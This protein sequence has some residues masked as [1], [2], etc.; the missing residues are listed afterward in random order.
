MDQEIR[1]CHVP[2][3]V[4]I[5]Y[6]TSGEGPLLVKAANWL[7]HLEFDWESPIWRHVFREL[8]R[9]HRLVRYDERGNGLSD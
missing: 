2:D 9:D 8:T 7:N 4:R 1:F 5:A 6:A 3:G